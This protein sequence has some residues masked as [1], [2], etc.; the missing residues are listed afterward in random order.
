V[1]NTPL[2]EYIAQKGKPIVM[3]T[4]ASTMEEVRRAYKAARRHNDQICLLQCTA[5]YPVTNYEEIDLNVIG[6]YRNEFPESIVGYSG[7]E[8]GIL[9]PVVAYVLGAR[10]VEK[11]F[12][13]NRAMK[14][15]DHSFSLEPAGLL[16]VAR[17][18]ERAHQ[19]LG[20]PEKHFYPSERDPR[21]KMGKSIVLR[22]PVQVGDIITEGL[23]AFKSP[24]DGICPAEFDH[25]LGRSV[26][27]DLP[28]DTILLWEHL[29]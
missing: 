6:T 24:G 18:L 2:I 14:G 26:V 28:E 23:V 17:D 4:G 9:L 7:H 11:H 8:S 1:T 5:G 27:R 19:A 13:L 21:R 25:V 12:T 15:T 10:V 3:S 29:K 16:K 20:S 22:Q